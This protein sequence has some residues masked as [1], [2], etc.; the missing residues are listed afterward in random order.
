M[1]NITSILSKYNINDIILVDVGAKDT[2]ENINEL[3][4][5]THLHAFEPTKIEC[6]KLT[7][8]YSQTPFKS[9][10]IN[11]VGL[12]K[13]TGDIKFYISNHAAMSGLLEPDLENYEKHFGAYL[14]FND[15]NKGITTTKEIII[16]C[17][18]LDDYAKNKIEQI[19]Y[20]KIDTQ[21][22]EL[23]I[24]KGAQQLLNQ[25][26]I[27]VIK[28]EV[29]TISIYKNQALFSDIDLYLRK[30]NYQMVDFITYRN[31]K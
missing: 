19:D 7:E 12:A 23:D 2:I 20:L 21:G 5:I 13:Q 26:K 31:E 29:S 10:T 17:E 4:E 14:E 28:V 15:W 1:N 22:T 24:L 6:E 18:A 11:N 9:K 25:R 27:H 30:H 8:K 3:K 16:K